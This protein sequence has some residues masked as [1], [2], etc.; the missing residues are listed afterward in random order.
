MADFYK[1]RD[2]RADV[3]IRY[4]SLAK[5]VTSSQ[6]RRK[7]AGRRRR[8][9][10]TTSSLHSFQS[11]CFESHFKRPGEQMGPSAQG[12]SWPSC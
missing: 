8:R 1:A 9:R 3:N 10:P 5:L 11:L 12:R 2:D 7:S 4:M 6:D